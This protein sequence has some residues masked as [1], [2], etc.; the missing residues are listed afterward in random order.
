M[1]KL[2]LFLFLMVLF[3]PIL[4]QEAKPILVTKNRWILL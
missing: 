1:K 2:N 3:I 4:G